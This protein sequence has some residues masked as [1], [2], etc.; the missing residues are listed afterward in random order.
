MRLSDLSKGDRGVITGIGPSDAAS[1]RLGHAIPHDEL[2]R[3][4]LEMGFVEGARFQVL[5]EGLVGRDPIAIKL[6]DM[7]LALRRR[8]ASAVQVALDERGAAAR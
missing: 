1:A 6:D 3:R 2:E 5:H 7:R 8:E 4:L